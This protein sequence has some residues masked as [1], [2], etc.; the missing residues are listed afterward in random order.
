MC[1]P[2]YNLLSQLCRVD[3]DPT[4]FPSLHKFVLFLNDFKTLPQ[5]QQ[6]KYH[7]VNKT[8]TPQE[9]GFTAFVQP[10][11]APFTPIYFYDLL[12]KFNP[13]STSFQEDTQEFL[14]FVLD[15]MHDE[16]AKVKER[17]AK[18][19][20]QHNGD[21]DGWELVG[22]N[23]ST[24]ILMH[25]NFEE[26]PI[27]KIFGG[28]IRSTVKKRDAGLKASANSQPF[29][30]LHLDIES[31]SITS[32]QTALKFF[33][34]PEELLDY[35]D[36]NRDVRASK[37]T[38]IDV[39]PNVLILHLKRFAFRSQ[40]AVKIHKFIQYPLTLTFHPNWLTSPRDYN[41]TQ[42]TYNLFS[43]KY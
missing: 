13:L 10:Y 18:T 38:T 42:R 20:I 26:S 5:N 11:G 29:F 33:M 19:E 34:S 32:I 24:V 25:D 27:T 16:L 39:L 31:P 2:F 1:A 15:M 6:V 28:K 36:A 7:G 41:T 22:K 21:D 35:Q 4:I 37:K 43:G 40:G 14:C 23:Q 3:I 12:K 17:K 8:N 9:N 30:C